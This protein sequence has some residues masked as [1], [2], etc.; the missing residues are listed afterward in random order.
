VISHTAV[1]TRRATDLL[2]GGRGHVALLFAAVV[3]PPERASQATL[4][5]T[6]AERFSKAIRSPS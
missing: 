1:C 2:R 3:V 6:G 4:A 5:R